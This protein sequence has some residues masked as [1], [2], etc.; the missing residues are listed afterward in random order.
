MKAN[1]HALIHAPPRL[2]PHRAETP[3]SLSVPASVALEQVGVPVV[4]GV[5]AVRMVLPVSAAV[6]AGGRDCLSVHLQV[7]QFVAGAGSVR[8]VAAAAVRAHQP[9]DQGEEAHAWR[10]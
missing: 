9:E 7:H 2:R 6:R 1:T 5:P 4:V 3:A 10:R 8:R